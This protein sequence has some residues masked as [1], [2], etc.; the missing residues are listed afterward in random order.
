MIKSTPLNGYGWKYYFGLKFHLL[1]EQTKTSG[2]NF[3]NTYQYEGIRGA[4]FSLSLYFLTELQTHFLLSTGRNL[5]LPRARD[6]IPV[7]SIVY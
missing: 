2:R 3:S 4:L 7:L 6:H 1:F 5:L